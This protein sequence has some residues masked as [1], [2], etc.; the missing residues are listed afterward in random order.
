MCHRS[1]VGFDLLDGSIRVSAVEVAEEVGAVAPVHPQQTGGLAQR[2][3]D[4]ASALGAVEPAGGQ[5]R[6]ALDDVGRDQRVLE[7]ERHHL[8][9]G[10]EHLPPQSRRPIG[11]S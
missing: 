3:H 1:G 10:V 7:V 9:P 11:A 4:V 2:A 6:V 8:P 5:E